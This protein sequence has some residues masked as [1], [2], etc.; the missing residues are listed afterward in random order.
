MIS[1]VPP[2][3]R[4]VGAHGFPSLIRLRSASIA[5]IEERN[6]SSSPDS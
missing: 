3:V 2:D 1:G 6:E 4:F 5:S